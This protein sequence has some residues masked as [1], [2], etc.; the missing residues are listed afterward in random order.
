MKFLKNPVPKIPISH[1]KKNLFYENKFSNPSD[2]NDWL[3]EGESEVL[4]KDGWLEMYSPDQK[5][6]HVFWCPKELPSD[7]MAEWELQNLNPDAGLCI[8]FAAKGI[9][10][11]DVMHPSLIKRNGVFRQYTQ[12]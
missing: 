11:K 3:L 12:E 10:G 1:N 4:I 5:A 6:H 2:I 9:N 7:F 8:V